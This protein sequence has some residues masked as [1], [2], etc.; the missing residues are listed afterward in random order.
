MKMS[1]KAFE[2]AEKMKTVTTEAEVLKN[3]GEL[4]KANEKLTEFDALKMAFDIEQ[5]LYN[6]NQ[7]FATEESTGVS[8]TTAETKPDAVKTFANAVRRKFMFEGASEDET[9]ENGGYIVPEDIQTKI[10]EYKTETFS[11]ED[12]ITVEKV[13]TNK[14]ARTFLT[15]S[16]DFGFE[17]VDENGEI[18]EI[19]TPTFE[20]IPYAIK[21]FG[22]YFGVSKDLMADT[23]ANL[24]ATLS[25]WI[26]KGVR[27]SANKAVLA[28]I[29][30]KSQTELKTLDD[31]KKT[32]LVTLGGAY[33]GAVT[34][35]TN[36]DGVNWLASLKD[37]NGRYLLNPVPSDPSK[38]QISV[39]ATVVPVV[40]V[41]NAVMPTT[42]SKMPVVI[43]DLKTAFTKF[44]RQ[45]I[46]ISTSDTAST[47]K[48]NAW[49]QNLMLYKAF[50][51]ADYV[52]VDDNAFVNGYISISTSKG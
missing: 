48:Y 17:Q 2:I 6:A 10:N 47:T 7:V 9:Y 12:Y 35:F 50:D 37:N 41:P 31:I 15:R 19:D 20:R 25:K 23:D 22:G 39:G 44:N 27:G 14:G 8:G 26:A 30:G 51:R 4:E 24:T 16:A 38:M 29:A 11:L 34:I 52:T 36:D 3:I 21:D 46:T 28:L 40:Q 43:G 1:K 33:R 45:Q 18:P 32:I 49:T 5:K 42:D 13:N